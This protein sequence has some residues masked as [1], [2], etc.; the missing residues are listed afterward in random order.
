MDKINNI[1]GVVNILRQKISERSA[2]DSKKKVSTKTNDV[3]IHKT[4]PIKQDD[5]IKSI[6]SRLSKTNKD[7]DN[8]REVV[9]SIIAESIITWEFGE[10]ILNDPGFSV[11]LNNV[12][13][14]YNTE[15]IISQKLNN[16][17]DRLG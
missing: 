8:H 6:Q 14:S 5:L 17:I 10:N 2:V 4:E 13:D 16:I 15:P 9:M 3:K 11:L 7:A 12:L 1:N